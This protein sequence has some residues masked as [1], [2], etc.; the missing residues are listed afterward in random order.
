MDNIKTFIMNR[1]DPHVYCVEARNVIYY[2]SLDELY[3]IGLDLIDKNK[4]DCLWLYH[5]LTQMSRIE[6]ESKYNIDSR[7][8][9]RWKQQAAKAIGNYITSLVVRRHRGEY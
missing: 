2:A 6:L 4:L 8:V 1:L 9:F 5:G 7:T 3:R